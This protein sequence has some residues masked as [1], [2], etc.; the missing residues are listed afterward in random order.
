MD[1]WRCFG[2]SNGRLQRT[3]HLKSHC[4]RT[5]CCESLQRVVSPPATM[6]GSNGVKKSLSKSE[7]DAELM[8]CWDEDCL[9]IELQ[10]KAVTFQA[11][12]SL[13]H[14]LTSKHGAK[15]SSQ[16]RL[17]H[18]AAFLGKKTNYMRS[19]PRTPFCSIN[20]PTV[21]SAGGAVDLKGTSPFNCRKRR[22]LL[23]VRT[24][25]SCRGCF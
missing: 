11:R 7:L 17:N 2:S 5:T 1:D 4:S 18:I 3:A 14:Q 24:Y 16:K 10:L 25:L 21:N 8:F 6:S 13:R 15:F 20:M 19:L 12:R 22:L 23:Q 9:A